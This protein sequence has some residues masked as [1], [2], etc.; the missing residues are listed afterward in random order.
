VYA[1]QLIVGSPWALAHVPTFGALAD[2]FIRDIGAGA[3][4]NGENANGRM[5]IEHENTVLFAARYLGTPV[6]LLVSEYAK[7]LAR[8]HMVVFAID[9]HPDEFLKVHRLPSQPAATA[10]PFGHAER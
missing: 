9:P 8:R 7:E 1:I 10:V 4:K 3:F 5:V 2:D 6:A